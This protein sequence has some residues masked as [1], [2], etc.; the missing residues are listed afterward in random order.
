MAMCMWRGGDARVVAAGSID[1]T[2]WTPAIMVDNPKQNS[3]TNP[4]GRGHQIMP[5]ITFANGRLTILY[6]DLRYDHYVNFYTP[7]TPS[8]TY[9]SVLTPEGELAAPLFNPNEIFTPYIDDFGLTVRR[10]TI[11]LRVLELGIFPTVTLGPSVSVSQYAYGCCVPPGFVQ[12]SPTNIEQYKFNV[13]NLPL[14]ANGSE[15]FLGDYIEVVPSPM[16]VP[17]GT[18]WAYNFTP[19]VNPLFHATWTDNRDVVPPADGNWGNYTPAVPLGTQSILQPGQTVSACR[20][21][22]EGMRNQNIYTAQITGGLVVGAPGNAKPL[23]TTTFNGKTV[24]FQRAFA[25]EAQNVTN[26]P[27]NVRLTIANQ[28]PGGAA[29]FLQF[30]Q[31]TTLD[32]TIPAFSSVSRSV[33]VTSSNPQATVTVNFAQ[34]NA[35][36]GSVVTNGLNSSAVLNPDITNPS[37]TNPS[38]TNPSITNPSITNLEVTNPSITNPSITNPSIT[39]P[40]ITNPSI[41][42][43]SITNPSITNVSATNPSI[44]NPSITNP[45]ITNPSITNPSITNPDI[46]NGSIQD[47][48]YPLSSNANTTATYT[49]KVAALNPPPG[50]IVLQLIVNKLY[51]TP[52]ANNC[53]LGNETHW[54]TVSNIT[55]PKLFTASDPQLGNPDITNSVP[56]EASV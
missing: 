31:L 22:Q 55:N 54:V 5:A 41:T 39:N 28:P 36:G 12:Q 8:G 46:T 21:G 2:H 45:D 7:S 1:G 23:G 37:I 56:N 44:T 34:I 10:H 50:G 16:F 14:F 29:S 47:V 32:V 35:I 25:V 13:P 38:I 49:V 3:V 26:Q 11:D 48:I 17:H 15:P 6:Y 42:N 9:T 19:S 53:Q 20:P 27:L 4:S 52:V 18:G 30:S 51:Q 43:P 33:F 24:P 40:S